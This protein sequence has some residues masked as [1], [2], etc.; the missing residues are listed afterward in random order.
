MRFAILEINSVSASLEILHWLGVNVRLI[1][2][3]AHSAID[4]FR[5]ILPRTAAIIKLSKGFLPL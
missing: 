4:L 5:R 1:S 3:K 2:S